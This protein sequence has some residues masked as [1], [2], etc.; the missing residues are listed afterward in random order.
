MGR[1]K[2]EDGSPYQIQHDR[3]HPLIAYR[4]GA[5]NWTVSH[6]RHIVSLH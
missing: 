1:N 5:G 4:H 2:K 3:F 6:R